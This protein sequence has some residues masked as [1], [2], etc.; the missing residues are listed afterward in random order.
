MKPLGAH[1]APYGVR[2]SVGCAARTAIHS[3][4]PHI[5]EA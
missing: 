5:R 4:A 3:T 2:Q 1:G